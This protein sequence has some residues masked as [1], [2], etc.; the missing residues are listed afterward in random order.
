M[1]IHKVFSKFREK[2]KRFAKNTHADSSLHT[3]Q[4]WPVSHD[5]KPQQEIM[6][7]EQKK[8]NI[9][10]E[11]TNFENEREYYRDIF[12]NQPAGMY[13]L[14]VFAKS[15][16]ELNKLK[17]NS[18]SPYIMEFATDKYY[19]IIGLS[20]QEL[21]VNPSLFINYFSPNDQMSF[22]KANNIA[23]KKLKPFRW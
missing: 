3:N 22:V 19:E 9:R 7:R 16:W 17:N 1:I 14:R 6:N 23:N 4:L 20:K 13:R 21:A 18:K 15:N 10:N 2:A 12:N 11:E 8:L 5:T